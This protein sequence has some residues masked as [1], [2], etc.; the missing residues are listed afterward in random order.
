MQDSLLRALVD[1]R[2]RQVQK[3]R[4][5]F[6]NRLSA[7]E[8]E[9]DDDSDSGQRVVLERYLERFADLEDG[10]DKDIAEQVKG[11]PMYEQL[12]ALK[13]I[14]PILSTKLLSM[15]DIELAPTVSSLWRFAGFGVVD[16]Q[17]EKRTKGE[18]AH[19]N[20]RLKTTCYLAGTSFLRS[21]S[22]YRAEYDRAKERY[23]GAHPDWTKLH[24]HHAAMGNMI[25]LFLSHLWEQW[26][27]AEG[28]PVR[29]AYV[30]EHGGHTSKK[31]ADWYGWP[32]S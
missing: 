32:I 5:Q 6:G 13:G 18:K 12:S 8:R 16:G 22:P 11:H 25:K 27:L 2:D 14:G 9:A 30:L 4:I 3:A 17:R 28:L 1:L 21:N 19:Y 26:R 23:Q 31:L 15:I 10:L 7:I 24:I 29:P 20:G